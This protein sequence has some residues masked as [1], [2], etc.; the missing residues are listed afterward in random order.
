MTHA[1][2]L[3][4]NREETMLTMTSDETRLDAW[5]RDLTAPMRTAIGTAP[6]DGDLSTWTHGATIAALVRHGL[7]RED[8]VLTDLGFQLRSELRARVDEKLADAG[9]DKDAS[10]HYRSPFAT[11]RMSLYVA[12]DRAG[13]SW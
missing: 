3:T 9:Y 4:P 11:D 12:M 7:A 2:I 13:V 5:R 1:C 8:R 10:G 6:D